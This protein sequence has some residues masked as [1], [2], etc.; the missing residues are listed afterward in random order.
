VLLTD[1]WSSSGEYDAL[2]ERMEA[3]GI[4]LSAVGAGGGGANEFL[5]DLAE[6]GGG[7]Y[8]PAVNPAT[9]PDIFLKETRQ[10][11]GQQIVEEPFFP[12]QTGDS[13]ILRGLEEGLPQLLGY[14]GTTPKP[15][16]Q[17]VLVSTR[18]DPVL[19]QWQ[20]GL[21]RAVAWTSDATARWAT[22]WVAWD[23]FNRFFSQL[24]GWTFPGE[25]S[26]GMEAEFVTDGD[27]TR[28][29]LRSVESDG[30]S[31]DFYDTIAR[32]T[33]PTLEALDPARMEQVAPGTYE[34]DLGTLDPGPYAVRI[35]QMRSGE[36]ALGRTVVLVAPTPAEY[37]LLGTN[38]R[39]LGALRGATGG[40]A[41]ETGLEAWTRD[42][43][44]TTASRDLWPWLLLAALLL[45][46]LDVGIRRVSVGRR[47]LALARAWTVQRWK[48]WRGPAGRTAPVGGM[49]AAKE[50]AAGSR[51]RAA[52]FQR[53]GDRSATPVETGAATSAADPVST[54]SPPPAPAPSA[55]A[56]PDGP[57]TDPSTSAATTPAA[58]GSGTPAASTPSTRPEAVPAD[59][60]ARLKE[61][62]E[63]ARRR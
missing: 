42:L 54:G 6:R 10:V 17:T 8:Y 45:W 23:G 33:T 47:D 61:A 13:P 2:L 58:S 3:A 30:T 24:V 16:A 28:L 14:N 55:L 53:D 9:I 60:M 40:R 52:L 62:R 59:T 49:L 38:E 20:Y 29:R 25:E 44:S 41:L 26:E 19:S 39:L 11:S 5:T 7:R 32:I 35:D 27:E 37:R 48:R 22:N 51:T 12:I 50:R 18:D 15:A 56:S 21:G 46:P 43:A 63:R 34:L 31:R 4:T 1:G 36:T 57:R